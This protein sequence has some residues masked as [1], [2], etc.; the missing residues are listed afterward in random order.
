[1]YGHVTASGFSTGSSL[2]LE[3]LLC[4]LTGEDRSKD[5]VT[6]ILW[7]VGNTAQQSFI[8]KDT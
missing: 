8:L 5:T 4:V 3:Y 6:A 7:F 2:H 1:M